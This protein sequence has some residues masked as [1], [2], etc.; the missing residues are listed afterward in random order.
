MKGREREGG[1][2]SREIYL[3]VCLY[4]YREIFFSTGDYQRHEDGNST[5][6]T[7]QGEAERSQVKG[8]LLGLNRAGK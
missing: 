3:S 6:A 8:C 7:T 5:L 2:G 4:V 1:E